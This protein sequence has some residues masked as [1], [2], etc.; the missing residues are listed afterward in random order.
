MHHRTG[1]RCPSACWLMVVDGV[2]SRC[3]MLIDPRCSVLTWCRRPRHHPGY[4]CRY[5]G[6]QRQRPAPRRLPQRG[7]G[8]VGSSL[9]RRRA[10]PQWTMTLPCCWRIPMRPTSSPFTPGCGTVPLLSVMAPEDPADRPRR[11]RQ[12]QGVGAGCGTDAVPLAP[13]SRPEGVG[14][15]LLLVLVHPLCQVRAHPPL[16]RWNSSP[17]TRRSKTHRRRGG[18][19]GVRRCWRS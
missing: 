10:S 5:L 6:R 13:V 8:P 12:G 4:G 14:A 17:M 1:N 19:S 7:L 11:L 3:E 15:A 2:P 16:D 9:R 18:A